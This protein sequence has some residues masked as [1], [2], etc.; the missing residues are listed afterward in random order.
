MQPALKAN[1]KTKVR[2]SGYN[3]TECSLIPGNGILA[4]LTHYAYHIILR[5]YVFIIFTSI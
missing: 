4:K 3:K 5:Y 2:V 1:V